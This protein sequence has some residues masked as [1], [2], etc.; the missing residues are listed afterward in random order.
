MGDIV[1]RRREDWEMLR[2]WVKIGIRV[3]HE[4]RDRPG[5]IRSLS[6]ASGGQKEM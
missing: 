1:G 2:D 4:V 3:E 6:E 5:P